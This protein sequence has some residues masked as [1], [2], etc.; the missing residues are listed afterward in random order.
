MI[1]KRF[2]ILIL[3]SLL[4]VKSLLYAQEGACSMA[5]RWEY[6]GIAIDEPGYYVWGSSP[7]VE[8][9]GK[10]HL[11]SA[12]WKIEHSFDPGWRTHS[13]IAHY[14]ADTPK[15]P[16]KFVDIVLQGSSKETWDSHSAH[17][18]LIRKVGDK[19]ALLYISNS[20][21]NQPP[22]PNNQKIGMMTSSSLY[23]PWEKVGEDGCILSPSTN[24]D[25]WTY[26]A[27]NGVNNPALL[28]HP[29]GGFYLYFKSQGGKMG[30]A[31]A[32]NLEGPYVILPTPITK[33]EVA[34]ED[35]YTFIWNDQVHLLT[36]DNH[37]ILNLGGGILWSSKDG[38]NFD[39]KEA[40]YYPFEHY[41]GK[42]MLK[43]GRMV[44][45]AMAKFERPQVLIIDG[46]P[47]WL[48]VPSGYNIKGD[49]STIVH[50]L[51]YTR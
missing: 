31:I 8:D 40:G 50:V 46:E 41:V 19:Y 13:E 51:S 23:G 20:N 4:S 34:I 45:G 17:N 27:T 3:A 14:V 47:K 48:Y 32:E 36:T 2:L 12:R 24:P 18:P 37:G 42:E 11:F 25:N 15:G 29:N 1:A 22:H 44:Y 26:K 28:I 39:E 49:N 9:D 35:G 43:N 10:V 38:I 33:N 6:Q 21:P 16:F 7:I 5:D 30:L